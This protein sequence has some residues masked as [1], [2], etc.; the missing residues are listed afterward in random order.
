MKEKRSDL[1]DKTSVVS[2]Y[3]AAFVFV[4]LI[5]CVIQ[6]QKNRSE[7]PLLYKLI[8][9]LNNRRTKKVE[10]FEWTVNGG[11]NVSLNLSHSSFVRTL[12]RKRWKF[13][14]NRR[15]VFY[16]VTWRR[17][18]ST[19]PSRPSTS[20]SLSVRHDGAPVPFT[21]EQDFCSFSWLLKAQTFQVIK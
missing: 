6:T 8:L 1:F 3:T 10:T 19:P 21:A 5:W 12:W 17:S 20:S 18:A 15:I 4:G 9:C 7:L 14:R 2:K 13:W 16:A 11:L